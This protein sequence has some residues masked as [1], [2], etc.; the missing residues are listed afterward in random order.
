MVRRS[1]RI[2]AL[3]SCSLIAL[4]LVGCG[5]VRS[6]LTPELK[7]MSQRPADTSNAWALTRNE[8][9]RMAS[10][11]ARRVFLMDRSSRLTPYATGR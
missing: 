9:W 7:T 11:D 3:A 10:E 5:G 4:S 1:I 2:A 8:N 6:N